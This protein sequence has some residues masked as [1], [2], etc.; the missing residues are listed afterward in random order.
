MSVHILHAYPRE[1]PCDINL[2]LRGVRIYVLR[3]TQLPQKHNRITRK[4]IKRDARIYQMLENLLSTA[5]EIRSN[6]RFAMTDA[7]PRLDLDMC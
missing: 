1:I 6:F 5:P 4:K 3:F 7:R 2:S